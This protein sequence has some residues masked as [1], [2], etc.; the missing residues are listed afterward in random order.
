[1]SQQLSR[2]R[3]QATRVGFLT[4][5]VVLSELLLP[6]AR[7]LHARTRVRREANL[8]SEF[9]RSMA[10]VYIPVVI[11]LSSL[12]LIVATRAKG[13]HRRAK[14]IV[15]LPASLR[16]TKHAR[17][18]TRRARS[19]LK[20]PTRAKP[21]IQR[22]LPSLGS[23]AAD[24]RLRFLH[25]SITSC[26]INRTA[27]ATRAGIIIKSSRCPSKGIKSG[28]RSIGDAAYATAATNSH[29]ASRGVR[30]CRI[31]AR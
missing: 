20:L 27:N 28:I 18:G 26:G 9:Y 2:P 16:A 3:T 21:G 15:A 4:C 7:G 17:R 11:L 23:L 19:Y 12:F 5:S 8:R 13:R 30:G 1:M 14:S 10:L 31:A 24:W 6:V 29:R 22:R 25:S